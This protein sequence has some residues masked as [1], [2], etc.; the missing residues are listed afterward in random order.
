MGYLNMW[1]QHIPHFSVVGYLRFPP[2][3]RILT[4][5]WSNPNVLDSTHTQRN[6]LQH[7]NVGTRHYGLH[8][9]LKSAIF[10]KAFIAVLNAFDIFTYPDPRD[11]TVF[12]M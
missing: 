12:V 4:H 2:T 1:F 11:Y 9:I 3:N 5:F 10:P 8:T 6:V 7:S